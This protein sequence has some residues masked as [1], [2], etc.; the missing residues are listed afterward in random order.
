M[1]NTLKDKM[2]FNMELTFFIAVKAVTRMKMKL[3]TESV[4]RTLS[5]DKS[6]RHFNPSQ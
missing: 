3:V 2:H 1:Y 6:Y 5:D 4:D